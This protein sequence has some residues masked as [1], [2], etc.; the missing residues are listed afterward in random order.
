V[1]RRLSGAD[2]DPESP[3]VPEGSAALRDGGD[4]PGGS[5]AADPPGPTDSPSGF[6]RGRT[7]RCPRCRYDLTGT[8]FAGGLHCPECGQVLD[9]GILQETRER[10]FFN[11]MGVLVIVLSVVGVLGT[12]A[13]LVLAP[14]KALFVVPLFVFGAAWIPFLIVA[15]AT[16]DMVE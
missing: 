2:R 11:R 3:A 14:E 7:P 10:R 5:A 16:R 8:L 13:V 15:R 9:P 4:R 12:V 6:V 1:E